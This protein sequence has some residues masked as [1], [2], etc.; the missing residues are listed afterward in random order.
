MRAGWQDFWRDLKSGELT[1]LL[2]AL[3]LAVTATTTLRHFSTGIE[4]G[5][6]QEAARLI[7]AD[8]VLRS[9]RP[10]PDAVVAHAEEL[11]LATAQTL[12]FAS[13]LQGETGFQL[14]AIKAVSTGY[15]LRGQ[16]RLRENSKDVTTHVTP[17]KGTLWVDERL[18]GLLNVGVGST[19]VLGDRSFRIAAVLAY[20]PDRGGNFAAF[21]P[22][23][24]MAMSDVA[25]TGIIQPGS[26]LQYQLLLRGSEPSLQA[27]RTWMEPRLSPGARLLDVSGGRPEL[28]NPLTR[29]SD[30]LG[31]AAIAAVVL[32]GLAIAVSAR[33]FA[34]RRYDMQ[35]LLRCLGASRK[36]ALSRVLTE[37]L[38]VWAVAIL[39]GA[40][41]GGMASSV[42]SLLLADLLP[43]RLPAF[44]YWRPLLTGAATATLTLLGFALPA[45]L[46]LGRVTPLR[47]LRR[48]LLPPSL[49]QLAITVLSLSALFLLLAL[50]TGR[51]MLTAIAVGGGALLVLAMQWGLHHLFIA[52]RR[53]N[54]AYLATLRRHPAETATQILGLALGLT[55]LLLVLSLRGELLGAWQTKIPPGAPNQFALN[56]ASHELADFETTLQSQGFSHE[57]LYPVVRGRLTGINDQPVQQA[58]SKE[59]EDEGR[60]ESLNRELNLT[61]SAEIPK[62]NTLTEGR[63][64]TADSV[65]HQEV[66]LEKRLAERL[67]LKLGDRL[68]FTLAEGEFTTVISSLREVDWD[69][70]QPNFYM[71]FPPGMID[72]FPASYMTSFNVP[73]EQRARLNTLARAFPTVVLIDIANV[74]NEVKKILDQV[75]RAIEAVLVFVLIAGL[76]VISA[77]V[78]A[79]LDA[80]RYEAALLRVIGASKRELQRRLLTEFVLLGFFAGILAALMSELLAAIIYWKVLELT[81]TLHPMLWWQAPVAGALLV[82]SAGMFGARRV[83][84]ASPLLTLRQ[85]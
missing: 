85:E 50:E 80:R 75:S 71:I 16:L 8:L 7:G 83:W 24:M 59:A 12:E 69:S 82:S 52:S 67:Q 62:G 55:A 51:L 73:V 76:L 26:R 30:Y 54:N 45:L 40:V 33:R 4:K 25:A 38:L 74:M 68:T 27:F 65:A 19:V 31:L 53:L 18:L 61:W 15:P 49:P 48:E 79:S 21:S 2:L 56:I 3:I 47:V 57:A 64:W 37:L 78:T 39:V 20:E 32:A 23:A 22:R 29:A 72:R 42:V 34:E 44:T 43:A 9:S 17:D 5:L 84:S 13:V 28:A 35:A 81:P 1:L 41:L 11:N 66:S 60:D 58:V 63:W 14:A 70:F 46:S 77:H 6:A 36:E 10:I